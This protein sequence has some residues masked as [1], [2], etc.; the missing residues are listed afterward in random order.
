MTLIDSIALLHQHQRSLGKAEVDGKT[1]EYV[2]VLPSDIET[3]N[4]LAHEVLGRS[5]DELPPQ[6]RRLLGKIDEMVSAACEAL[7]MDRT[8]YRFTR[9]EVRSFTG[10]GHTQLKLH[11]RR[12]E[13]FEYLLA[14]QGGRGQSFIY[15][16]VYLGDEEERPRLPGL[17]EVEKL[18]YDGKKSGQI[19][20]KSGP[21]RPQVGGVS[22]GGR[23]GVSPTESGG[24]AEKEGL[25]RKNAYKGP[26]VRGVRVVRPSTSSG[27]S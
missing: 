3:A 10:W 20:E 23:V 16:L 26:K 22:G 12:L 9:R 15:E 6:T 18:R 11:L 13:E 4:R 14:H 21:S 5:L 8:D 25:G 7:E 27:A 24:Y 19:S 2:E 1:V 17:I